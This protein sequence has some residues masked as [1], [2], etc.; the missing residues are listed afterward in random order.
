MVCAFNM[1][2][3]SSSA[4]YAVMVY[5][6]GFCNKSTATTVTEYRRLQNKSI[7][8]PRMVRNALQGL[9]ELFIS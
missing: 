7:P 8:D 5:V 4:E 6:Y 9:R 2:S 1:S 3:T